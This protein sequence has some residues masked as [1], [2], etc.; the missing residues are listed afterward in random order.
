MDYFISIGCLNYDPPRPNMKQVSAWRCVLAVDREITRYYRWWVQKELFIELE[1]PSWDAHITVTEGEEPRDIFKHLWKQ[2]NGKRIK[3]KYFPELIKGGPFWFVRVS[4][5]EL[6]T[7]RY[8]LGLR[9][10]YPF[11]ITIGREKY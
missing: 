6:Y 3:F 9:P 8:N 4:C 7:V 10:Y 11:H 2:D 1:K 5:P